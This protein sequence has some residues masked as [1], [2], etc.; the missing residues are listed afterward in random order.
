MIESLIQS[1]RIH[2]LIVST[3]NRVCLCQKNSPNTIVRANQIAV[4]SHVTVAT[5]HVTVEWA[6]LSDVISHMTGDGQVVGGAWGDPLTSHM[7]DDWQVVG[8]A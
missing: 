1:P 8:G 4:F 3:T 6:G 7:T 5:G 2:S